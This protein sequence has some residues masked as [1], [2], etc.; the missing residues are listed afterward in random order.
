MKGVFV[1]GVKEI[2]LA[3][4]VLWVLL[5]FFGAWIDCKIRER[6]MKK[7][8]K[9]KAKMYEQEEAARRKCRQ[10]R[11]RPCC[12]AIKEKAKRITTK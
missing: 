2:L 8:Q 12:A 4:W 5:F 9:R 7:A 10:V 6:R 11:I 1:F 3:L